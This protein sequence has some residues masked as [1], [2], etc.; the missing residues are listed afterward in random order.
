MAS[1]GQ[2]SNDVGANLEAFAIARGTGRE[3]KPATIDMGVA[4]REIT[5]PERAL[6]RH[7]Q[8]EQLEHQRPFGRACLQVWR[9]ACHHHE[10]DIESGRRDL[11]VRRRHS[12]PVAEPV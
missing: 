4:G 3:R 11:P 1:F 7:R 6:N 5:L 9:M 8:V 10:A 12:R 2:I